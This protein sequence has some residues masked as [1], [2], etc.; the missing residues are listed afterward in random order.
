M[1]TKQ[2]LFIFD[3]TRLGVQAWQFPAEAFE[4]LLLQIRVHGQIN[5][6]VR[7]VDEQQQL[8]ADRRNQLTAHWIVCSAVQ[9]AELRHHERNNIADEAD[10]E[11]KRVDYDHSC[12]DHFG[13]ESA[14]PPDN[15]G[16]FYNEP[17]VFNYV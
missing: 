14:R 4:R 15:S 1:L 16:L 7:N 11:Q 9:P 17:L 5:K 12:E 10:Y 8:V 6:N 3:P 13:L 2:W